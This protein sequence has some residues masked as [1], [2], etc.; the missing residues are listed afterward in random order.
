MYLER[1]S[2]EENLVCLQCGHRL[3]VLRRAIEVAVKEAA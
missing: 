1:M 2:G 3:V